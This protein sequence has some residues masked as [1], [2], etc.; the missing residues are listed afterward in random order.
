MSTLDSTLT[1][2]K[3]LTDANAVPGQ[4]REA[5]LVMKKYIEDSADKVYQDNIGSLIAEKVGVEGGPKVVVAGHMDEVGFMVKLIEDKGFV[6][7]QTL[8]GW[9]SQVMLAQQVTITTS[10]G[11]TYH[12]VIGSTPPHILSPEARNKVVDIKEM[13]IDLGVESKEEVEKLGIKPGDMITP[14]IEFRQMANEKYLLAKA[15]DNRI[16]CAIAVEV[17]RQLKEE[18]H[19]NVV[20]GVG[21]VQEEVG[22]RGARTVAQTINPQIVFSA[23]VGIAGDVPGVSPNQVQAKMGK[24]P[25]ITLMDAG[26]IGH[27]GLRDF[28]VSVADELNIPYQ[29]DTMPGGGTDAGAMH[30]AHDGAPAMSVGVASRY[31][32]SHT[33]MIHRDDYENAVKLL[34]EVIKRLDADTVN[35][36]TFE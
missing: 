20:Y 24:G 30:L 2:L 4:E 36:I 14:Y 15:W 17:L 5:R 27:K 1:F 21:T 29:F 11:K 23:D 3:E 10:T 18:K 22:L 28:V 13:Y 31:I 26:L 7:F 6:R 34:V 35:K 32:H 9:W 25:I 33:S 12:G 8:G 16:G 19:P